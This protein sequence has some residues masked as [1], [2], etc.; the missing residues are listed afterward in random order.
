MDR[1]I[2]TVL[3]ITQ[4]EPIIAMKLI[5]EGVLIRDNCTLSQ[6]GSLHRKYIVSF[7]GL[8][9]FDTDKLGSSEVEKKCSGLRHRVLS[10]IPMVNSIDAR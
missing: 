3:H 5:N 8:F 1:S 6:K 10:L 9:F 2:S 4:T 7:C